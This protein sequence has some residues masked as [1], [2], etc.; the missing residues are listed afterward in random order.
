MNYSYEKFSYDIDK[1]AEQVIHTGPK[2]AGILALARGGAIPGVVLSHRIGIP[3]SIIDWSFRDGGFQDHF[4]LEE[5]MDGIA[6]GKRYLIVDDILD[7]GKTLIELYKQ[8]GLAYGKVVGSL[9]CHLA[10]L[11]KN[12]QCKDVVADYYGRAIDRE[13]YKEWVNFWWEK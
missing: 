7:T 5:F 11:I 13:T 4:A 8:L 2:Y 12:V 3:V 1:I 10:V 6:L 9:N